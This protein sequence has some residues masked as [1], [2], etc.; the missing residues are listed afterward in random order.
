MFLLWSLETI[1]VLTILYLSITQIFV[2]LYRGTPCLP[3]FRSKEAELRR[4]LARAR[5][6][7]VERDLQDQLEEARK[8]VAAQTGHCTSQGP[9][10]G[11][12]HPNPQNPVGI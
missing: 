6:E 5:Q 2:P 8:Q 3:M 1:F 10:D 12:T 11:Q 9:P 7:E 4:E